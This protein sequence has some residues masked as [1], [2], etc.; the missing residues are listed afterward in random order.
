MKDQR[1][2]SPKHNQEAVISVHEISKVF[3]RPV[4]KKI[5]L[6]VD[7]PQAVFI[8]GVNGAGKSTLLKILAGLLQPDSGSVLIGGK[9]FR[10][11]TEQVKSQLGI[12][13]HQSMV[14]PDLTVLENLEFFAC[15]YGVPQRQQRIAQLLE[16][17][18]LM[19]YRYDKAAILSRG[20]LQRLSIARAMIHH[21]RIILADEPFTGLDTQSSEYLTQMLSSFRESGGT[22][23]LTTHD[24]TQ[25]LRCSD[26]V[27]VIDQARIV[28]DSPTSRIDGDAFSKDYLLYSR[29]H[30]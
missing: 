18:G 5:S 13:M 10:R 27:I 8:C 16:Q 28:F 4:L 7:Q 3:A 29:N 25:G 26:R 6:S 17:V 15:L 22:V 11:D 12:I 21:P 20:L 23:V 14:Y 19:A 24:V 1:L 30:R 9:C 2:S